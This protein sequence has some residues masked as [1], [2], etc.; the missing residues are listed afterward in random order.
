MGKVK[1]L[2]WDLSP[3]KRSLDLIDWRF[4][5][6]YRI[7]LNNNYRMTDEYE[8]RYE[9]RNGEYMLR[10]WH[11]GTERSSRGPIDQRPQWLAAIVDVARVGQ[12]MKVIE[13]PPPECICWFATDADH[14]LTQFIELT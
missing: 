5:D 9:E 3:L 2:I 1:N 10:E 12:H 8:Y 11:D 13:Q 4:A 14:N 6:E 7:R